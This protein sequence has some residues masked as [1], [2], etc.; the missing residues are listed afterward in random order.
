MGDMLYHILKKS[1]KIKDLGKSFE[2]KDLPNP[3]ILNGKFFPLKSSTCA[4]FLRQSG[5]STSA[6]VTYAR[7]RRLSS[8]KSTCGENKFFNL[9]G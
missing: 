8:E 5:K 4:A 3:L 6:K 2:I 9:F 1:S 7:L